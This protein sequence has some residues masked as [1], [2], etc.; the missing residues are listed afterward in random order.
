MVENRDDAA[1][2]AF[3]KRQT[4][5][6]RERFLH[7]QDDAQRVIEALKDWIV[8]E[9]GVVWNDPLLRA[10]AKRPPF[11][12]LIASAQ[13][14]KLVPQSP[15]DFWGVVTDMIGQPSTY[16]DLTDAEWITVMNK[17]GES[18]RTT[19]AC[20]R[21]ERQVRNDPQTYLALLLI[22]FSFFCATL[23]ILAALGFAGWLVVNLVLSLG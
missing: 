15:R 17:F 14:Q 2:E 7:H 8:R 20:A 6:E 3:V 13:W 12:F 4:G 23:V 11:G 1:L 10:Q 5:L 16:R 21:P 19:S 18:I 9:G 22:M